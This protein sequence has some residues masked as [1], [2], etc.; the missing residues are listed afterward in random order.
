VTKELKLSEQLPGSVLASE[1]KRIEE[2]SVAAHLRSLE[3]QALS[4]SSVASSQLAATD[5]AFADVG[6]LYS[7]RMEGM[8]SGL[9]NTLQLAESNIARA[10]SAISMTHSDSIAQAV[11]MWET[12]V[13]G[14]LN[15]PD[16]G[17]RRGLVADASWVD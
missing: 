17:E 3:S 9:R 1:L 16:S 7:E 5:F 4:I 11:R 2:G 12:S 14:D 6:R 15:P 13:D 8:A 10:A